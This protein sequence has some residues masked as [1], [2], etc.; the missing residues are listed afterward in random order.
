MEAKAWSGALIGTAAYVIL[1][2]IGCS[3]VFICCFKDKPLGLSTF[4]LCGI[5]TWFLWFCTYISQIN[6]YGPPEVKHE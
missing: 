3:L 4:I 1:T 5:C 2:I 6:P